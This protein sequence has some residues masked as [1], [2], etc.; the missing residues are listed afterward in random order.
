MTAW[1]V[2]T[3]NKHPAVIVSHTDR[4]ARKPVVEVLACN[5]ARAN[6]G[7]RPGEVLLDSADGLD[8]ETICYCDLIY[9]VD[10]VQL[11]ARRGHVTLERQRA[12][13][14]AVLQSHGW[15]GL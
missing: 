15:I 8:W 1:D 2:W 7:P 14:V 13:I 9:A 12:I 4:A 3:W 11:S 5:K 6:R 10:R